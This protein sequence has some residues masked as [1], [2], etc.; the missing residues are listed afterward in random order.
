VPA[1]WQIEEWKKGRAVL[2]YELALLVSAGNKE[3]IKHVKSKI[4]ALDAMIE[5]RSPQAC[6]GECGSLSGARR[7]SPGENGQMSLASVLRPEG[8]AA[9]PSPACRPESLHTRPV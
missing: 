7:R 6:P 8:L 1:T 3:S 9:R 4:A 5:R 2:A